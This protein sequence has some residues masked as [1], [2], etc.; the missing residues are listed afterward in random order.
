MLSPYLSIPHSLRS[1]QSAPRL[2]CDWPITCTPHRMQSAARS[3]ARRAVVCQ[4]A[5]GG[6][7]RSPACRR[8]IRP[9]AV[10][11]SF[12]VPPRD[13]PVCAVRALSSF[14][15]GS[16]SAS[17]LS[18]AVAAVVVVTSNK[19]NESY[20]YRIGRYFSASN[21]IESNRLLGVSS[22]L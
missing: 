2:L 21:R 10:V 12:S 19:V 13:P 8:L 11:W 16:V 17:I 14:S 4:G 6:G 9:P 5:A 7:R 15:R 20:R 1:L 18:S 22:V 3:S